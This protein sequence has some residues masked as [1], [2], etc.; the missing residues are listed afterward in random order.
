MWR[1]GLTAMLTVLLAG[2]SSSPPQVGAGSGSPSPTVSDTPG[3]SAAP[4]PSPSPSATSWKY[5]FP[6]D[7][8]P[9]SYHRTHSGYAATDIFASC[10][11]AVRA[12]TDGIVLEV[13]RVDRFD[14][15]NPD[16]A[17]KGGLFVSIKGD[18]GV[19]YYG[20]HLVEVAAGI[21]KGV[22]VRNG[23]S[24]GAVGH[25]GNA[26]NIC[27]LHFGISPPCAGAADW[28]IRRGV[29]WPWP[30]L[31]A[32]RAKAPKSA[33]TEVYQW[34]REHGCPERAQ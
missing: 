22:R 1:S 31:D 13:S 5:T 21:E 25:T 15:A 8:N 20:A 29:V 23:Q 14:P 2:C 24:V 3:P 33:A 32:W 17:L 18:D 19:R 12:V 7:G 30:Y 10:G 6:V 16:P 11:S 28:W 26:S 4:S 9:V 27:H 34:H